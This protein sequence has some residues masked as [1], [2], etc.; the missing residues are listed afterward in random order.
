MAEELQGLLN[1]IQE[2]GLQKSE[3]QKAKIIADA[4]AKASAVTAEA[5]AEAARIVKEAE[6]SAKALESKSVEA[7]R[8][9]SRDI[10][11]ALKSELQ[12]R[13]REV[14]RVCVGEAM[15]PEVMAGLIN[16]MACAYA[17]SGADRIEL[18]LPEASRAKLEEGLKGCLAEDLRNRT[19]ILG[20]GDFTSGLQIGFRDGDVFLDFSDDALS[21]LICAYIGPKLAALLK[22]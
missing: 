2:D 8:Q 11:I 3:A 15:T 12:E 6:A 7:I 14:V 13:L 21:E 9:A 22:N 20:G 1:R 5:E 10:M 17:N 4:Q 18:L 16:E 19:K